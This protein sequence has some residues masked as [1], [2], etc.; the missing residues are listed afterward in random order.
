MNLCELL[1]RENIYDVRYAFDRYMELY[2]N[3]N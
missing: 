1:E 2:Q 3:I